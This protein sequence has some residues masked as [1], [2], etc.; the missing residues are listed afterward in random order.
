MK[1]KTHVYF[2]IALAL[3]A[4]TLPAFSQGNDTTDETIS[5]GWALDWMHQKLESVWSHIVPEAP[6]AEN[7][8]PV[9][10]IGAV[11]TSDTHFGPA[12]GPNGGDQIG[13]FM[14]PN[15]DNSEANFGPLVGP[16]G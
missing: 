5:I 8:A 12:A 14:E 3:S 11:E 4:L 13:G 7:A 15:G 6:A 10:E 16:N 2:V 1:S 9:N